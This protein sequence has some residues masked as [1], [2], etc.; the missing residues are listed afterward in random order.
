VEH[1]ILTNSVTVAVTLE[2]SVATDGDVRGNG[3]LEG[4]GSGYLPRGEECIGVYV[5][6]HKVHLIGALCKDKSILPLETK[7]NKVS[8]RL[9]T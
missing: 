8:P 7:Q 6:H 1:T 4:C 9:S 2:C 3:T 5:A